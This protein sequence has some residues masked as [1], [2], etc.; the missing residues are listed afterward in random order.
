M[1]NARSSL[2]VVTIQVVFVLTFLFLGVR[3]WGLQIGR[4]ENYSSLADKNRFR[5]VA[6]DPPRGVFY[7]RNGKLLVRNVPRFSLSVVPSALPE[8]EKELDQLCHRLAV[9][10]GLPVSNKAQ[11]A[12]LLGQAVSAD[13]VQSS[14]G[15]EEGIADRI[16]K[17]QEQ[18][19]NVQLPPHSPVSL[20]S[21][22]TRDIAF[23]VEEEQGNLPGVLVDIEPER[24]YLFGELIA[25][26]LGYVGAIPES[27]RGKYLAPSSGYSPQ[28]QVG[29]TGVELTYEED[30]RGRKGEKH[31]EVD[32]FERE[33]QTLATK[34][35]EAGHSLVL[36]LDVDLQRAAEKALRTRMDMVKSKSGT[37]IAMN[38][39]NG[40]LLAMVN[41][42]TY[43][44]NLFSGGI[45]VADYQRLITDPLSPLLNHA[46]GGEYPPGSTFKLV[47]ASGGM[48]SGVI[49]ERTEFTCQGILYLPNE[50]LPNDMSKAQP[51]YCWN[52][53]RPRAR[54]PDQRSRLLLRHL[55]LSGRRRL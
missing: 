22:I 28:D 40:E 31:I 17:I 55:F 44:N 12:P 20:V 37:V 54:E 16:A 50:Y 10:T 6:V 18:V 27:A 11:R 25:N 49:N 24:Q 7:D 21:E 43:D 26:W 46:I 45:S 47:A 1:N 19:D 41:L 3:L 2:R 33:M 9:I 34:P 8:D 32:A 42:P 51:F 15:P 53:A 30:L 39:Q 35:A 48:E 36:S 38:P 23:L 5:L 29:L 4:S 14:D 13:T 52:P